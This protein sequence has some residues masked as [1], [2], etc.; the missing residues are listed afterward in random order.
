MRRGTVVLQINCDPIVKDFATIYNAFYRN[1]VHWFCM[2]FLPCRNVYEI[3]IVPMKIV[4]NFIKSVY[5][6][7][8]QN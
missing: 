3:T 6:T 4:F 2:I 1:T 7:S 5:I 8:I